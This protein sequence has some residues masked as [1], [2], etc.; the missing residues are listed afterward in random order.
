MTSAPLLVWLVDGVLLIALLEAGWLLRHA[1]RLGFARRALAAN[2]AAGLALMVALRLALQDAA[3]V[4]IAACM[5][6]AGLAHALDLR[7]RWRT[8]GTPDRPD[9]AEA[10]SPQAATA[11][12]PLQPSSPR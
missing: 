12:T 1:R 10:G 8:A 2:L 3:P 11:A 5:A 9:S 6:A 4:W 7:A